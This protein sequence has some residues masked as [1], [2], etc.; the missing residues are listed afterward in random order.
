MKTILSRKGFDSTRRFGGGPSPI[1]DGRRLLSLPIPEDTRKNI[2]RYSE[3]SDPSGHFP[4]LGPLVKQLTAQRPTADERLTGDS[5]AHLD[6][7]LRRS[8]FP[9][10]EDWRP[11]F[12]QEGGPQTHLCNQGVGVGDLFLFYGLYQNVEVDK[13]TIRFVRGSQRMHVIWGWMTVGEKR[14]V[15]SEMDDPEWARYHA[16]YT[17]NRSQNNTVYVAADK[18]FGKF[19]GAGV[20]ENYSP[21]LCLTDLKQKKV[22]HSWWGLPLWFEPRKG[23]F[24]LTHHP[25][26]HPFWTQQKDQ[27]L[28]KTKSPGQEYVLDTEFYPEGEEWAESFIAEGT[29]I[30]C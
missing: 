7:D 4:S 16:H 26:Q 5:F 27:V 30:N 21:K 10:S 22:R 6:P 15:S 23:R 20:F 3:V 25:T 28:L 9:R 17:D 19:P 29:K 1:F 8:S 12:G 18:S 24:P 13:D 11:V 14:R 2:I